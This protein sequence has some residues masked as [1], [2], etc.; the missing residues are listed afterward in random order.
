MSGISP[1]TA[2]RAVHPTTA[3]CL[4][5]ER[6]GGTHGRSVCRATRLKQHCLEAAL[7][8]QYFSS[9]TDFVRFLYPESRT[10]S[11]TSFLFQHVDCGLESAIA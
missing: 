7:A 3:D 2:P 8:A 1:R 5:L 11:T 9:S 6:S 4:Q 10:N